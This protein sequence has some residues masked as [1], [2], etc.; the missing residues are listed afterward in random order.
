MHLIWWFY[1]Y[2]CLRYLGVSKLI[3]VNIYETM[4]KSTMVKLTNIFQRVA[5]K[6]KILVGVA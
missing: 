1:Y 5:L 2:S 6:F 4:E 3:S